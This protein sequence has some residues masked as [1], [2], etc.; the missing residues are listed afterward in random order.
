MD[1][2]VKDFYDL[3]KEGLNK[4]ALEVSYIILV[5]LAVRVMP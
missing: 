1:I 3:K 5:E 4:F 2:R